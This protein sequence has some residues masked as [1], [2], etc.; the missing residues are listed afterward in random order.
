MGMKVSTENSVKFAGTF[1]GDKKCGT[2]GL[3]QAEGS[4]DEVWLA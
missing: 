1:T 3:T 4:M 2:A